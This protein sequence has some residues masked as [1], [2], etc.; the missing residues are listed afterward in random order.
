MVRD[1]RPGSESSGIRFMTN[2]NGT[3]FFGATDGANGYELW[4]SDG[5][6]AGTVMVQNIHPTASSNPASLRNVGGVLYFSADE[7]VNGYVLWR[8]NGT[9]S[10]P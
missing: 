7:G 6:A 10:G 8:S 3:L 9:A 1:I 2:V 4:K 5:T